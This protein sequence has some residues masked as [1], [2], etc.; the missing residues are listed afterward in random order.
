MTAYDP[1]LYAPIDEAAPARP[2]AERLL[3]PLALAATVMA[4]VAFLLTSLGRPLTDLHGFRQAQTAISV[5]WMLHGGSWLD[6]W[7]PV[8]GAP[9]SAPFEFPF[10]QWL[11]AG[12][13]RATGMAIDPAGRIV[14]WLW[15]VAAIL[16]ARSLVR[17]CR[18]PRET[19]ALF[20]ILLLGSPVY[21]FWGRAFLIETQAVTLGMSAL[22]AFRAWTEHRRPVALLLAAFAAAGCVATKVTTAL[23]F[24]CL[25]GLVAVVA[26]RR[27]R[28]VAPRAVL[29]AGTVLATLPALLLFAWWTGRTDAIKAAGPLTAQFAAHAPLML[30]WN[31]GTLAQRLGADLWLTPVRALID[32]A[33]WLAPLALLLIVAGR[34]AARRD[35]HHGLTVIT[36]LLGA[37]LLPFAV[38]TNLHAVH[39][40]Y[41]AGNAVFLVGALALALA[42]L[43]PTIAPRSFALA[44]AALLASQYHRFATC[45]LPNVEQPYSQHDQDLAGAVRAV[46]RADAVVLAV[47]D[48]WSAVMPY[49][50]ERRAIMLPDM[51]DLPMAR[52]A[53]ADI[54]GLLGALPLGA[55]VL[56]PSKFSD[57]PVIRDRMAALT[58]RMQERKPSGDC[59]IFT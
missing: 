5:Y 1:T 28:G 21:L 58:A 43:R 51:F 12:L 9:W 19:T 3:L 6:Y 26:L 20:A 55:V 33:G 13:V 31:F 15:L 53:L 48:D 42:L 17:S 38:F 54:P 7:T 45:F 2:A 16:P 27:A 14:S 44:L 8:L 59:R 29:L 36:V 25:L 57:D 32:V 46:T 10:Y 30:G 41:Q 56:C 39:D 47:G 35:G 34:A 22:A 49:Y 18:L 11:V 37:W 4:S 50:A 23:S 24:F 40:Y 52:R